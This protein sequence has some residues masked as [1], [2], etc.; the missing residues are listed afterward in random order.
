MHKNGTLLEL[1]KFSIIKNL[2]PK[3]PGLGQVKRIKFGIHSTI[4]QK[5]A[6]PETSNLVQSF[7]LKM[8]SKPAYNIWKK[9][10]GLGH[11]TPRKSGIRSII[12]QKPMKL[13]TSNLVLCFVLA[14]PPKRLK[15]SCN[16]SEKW[17]GLGHVTARKFAYS[18]LCL[19]NQ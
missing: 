9:G 10:R 1:R 8:S 2:P 3:G 4:S 17:R 18:G 16:I 14:I 6:K 19:Q 15:R 5:A 7:A 13:E 11:V 12:S